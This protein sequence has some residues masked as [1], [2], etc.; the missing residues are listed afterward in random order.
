MKSLIFLVQIVVASTKDS[1]AWMWKNSEESAVAGFTIVIATANLPQFLIVSMKI[2]EWRRIERA[3]EGGQ[4]Y[5]KKL[6]CWSEQPIPKQESIW[7]KSL[8]V[9]HLHDL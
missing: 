3:I 4:T 5:N 2:E 1:K 7:V 8:Y 6:S 9:L